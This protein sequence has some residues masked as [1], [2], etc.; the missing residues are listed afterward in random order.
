M[1]ASRLSIIG[2]CDPE[3]LRGT[4]SLSLPLLAL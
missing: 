4:H 3:V 1:V 2:A